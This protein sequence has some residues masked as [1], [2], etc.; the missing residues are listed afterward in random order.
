MRAG[1]CLSLA[2]ALFMAAGLPAFAQEAAAEAPQEATLPPEEDAPPDAALFPEPG[3]PFL[4]VPEDQPKASEQVVAG[5]S[6]DAVSITTNFDGSDILIYGAVKRESPI[7]AEDKLDVI[8]TVQGPSQP[9]TVWRK[10][11]RLGIWINTERVKIGAS[12]SFYAVATTG[13]LDEILKPEWDQSFR[14]SIPLA[15]RS[16]GGPVDVADTVPFTQAMIQIREESG[17]YHL[18]PESIELTE[19]TLF[20]TN[21]RLPANLIEGDYGTRIFLLRGGEVVDVYRA[22]ILVRKVGLERWLY[23]LAFDQPLLYGLMS[24]AVA[25]AAGWGASTIFRLLRRG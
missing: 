13:P 1:A 16:F 5:L 3:H 9:V 21:I 23:R 14:I 11:R 4:V 8:V 20:R 18:E 25:V 10:E 2:I 19:E 7:P 22:P 17:L 24:L 15:M 12:P 6:R